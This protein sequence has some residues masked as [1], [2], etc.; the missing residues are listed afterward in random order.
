MHI[1]VAMHISHKDPIQRPLIEKKP[2][3]QGLDLKA[4]VETKYMHRKGS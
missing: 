1:F 2:V 4:S 3:R